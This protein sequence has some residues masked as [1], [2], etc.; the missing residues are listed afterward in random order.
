MA[1][2]KNYSLARVFVSFSGVPLNLGGSMVSLEID[3]ESN[4]FEDMIG[5]GKEV[6]IVGTEDNRASVTLTLAGYS[7]DNGI[8]SAFHEQRRITGI[9]LIA[10][11][12]IEQGN[13]KFIA[14]QAWIQKAPPRSYAKDNIGDNAWVFRCAD[15]KRLDL[16][17]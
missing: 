15:L 2:I 16:G 13:D 1:D 4:A 12:Y 11:L 17:N 3:N 10:A 9:P 14:E 8:L 6:A 5:T 7:A